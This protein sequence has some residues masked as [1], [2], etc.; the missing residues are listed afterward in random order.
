MADNMVNTPHIRQ[1]MNAY[2]NF[3]KE[4]FPAPIGTRNAFNISY[5]SIRNPWTLSNSFLISFNRA[6]AAVFVRRGN[7]PDAVKT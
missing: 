5:P 7:L 3:G 2:F 1:G 6:A 4:S